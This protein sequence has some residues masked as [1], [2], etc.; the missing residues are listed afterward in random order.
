[1]AS[2]A[3][4][5]ALRLRKLGAAH[6]ADVDRAPIRLWVALLATL[7]EGRNDLFEYEM[8]KAGIKVDKAAISDL[9]EDLAE[10]IKAMVV[11]AAFPGASRDCEPPHYCEILEFA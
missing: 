6:A 5:A 1:M 9:A 7:V 3:E 10:I 11:P 4:A 8:E 2:A